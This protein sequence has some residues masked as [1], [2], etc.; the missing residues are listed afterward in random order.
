MYDELCL[1]ELCD[2]LRDKF[3]SGKSDE[4]RQDMIDLANEI[5]LRVINSSVD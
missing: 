4:Y 3:Y 5:V 2:E 1:W